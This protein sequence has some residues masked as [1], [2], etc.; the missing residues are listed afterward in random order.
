[1]PSTPFEQLGPRFFSKLFSCSDQGHCLTNLSGIFKFKQILYTKWFLVVVLNW[2]HFKN[3]P[4]SNAS[5]LLLK[6]IPGISPV[7]LPGQWG[8]WWERHSHAEVKFSLVFTSKEILMLVVLSQV[9][10][11]SSLISAGRSCV[12]FIELRAV[13]EF[14]LVETTFI[15]GIYLL[16][17]VSTALHAFSLGAS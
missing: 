10:D 13:L 17:A 11:G 16:V 8:V 9:H 4:L 15:V 14:F 7:I 6:H 1:M 2:H 5:P 12:C 3:A